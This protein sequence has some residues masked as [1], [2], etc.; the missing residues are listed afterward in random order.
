MSKI[1]SISNKFAHDG[2]GG[3]D[4]V[5]GQISVERMRQQKKRI[6]RYLSENQSIAI[7]LFELDTAVFA[8]NTIGLE[9]IALIIRQLQKKL[10]DENSADRIDFIYSGGHELTNRDVIWW[11]QEDGHTEFQPLNALEP[12]KDLSQRLQT[13]L[14]PLF[15]VDIA[16]ENNELKLNWRL[17]RRQ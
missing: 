4:D 9:K 17:T 1:E 14:E 2:I 7:P 12:T 15:A 10:M 5:S 3:G 16:K 11:K 6:H 8:E 13:K